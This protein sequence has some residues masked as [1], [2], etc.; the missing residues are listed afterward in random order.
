MPFPELTA[1][2][3]EVLDLMAAGERNQAIAV[4]LSLSPKTVANHISSIFTKLSV[5]DRSAAI[6]RARREGLG[7]P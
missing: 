7:G 4:R 6:V 5:A 3:R 2:E 1:R